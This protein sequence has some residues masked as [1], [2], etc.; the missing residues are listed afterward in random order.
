MDTD[1]NPFPFWIRVHLCP[2][3]VELHR[4]GLRIPVFVRIAARMTGA[5]GLLPW[6]SLSG[7]A[8]RI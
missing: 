1:N 7:P 6:I 2:S 3:V 5:P 8:R 4:P